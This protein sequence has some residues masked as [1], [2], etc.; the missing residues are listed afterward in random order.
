M[1]FLMSIGTA[2]IYFHS[3]VQISSQNLI[4]FEKL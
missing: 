4:L 1:I 2:G 3:D